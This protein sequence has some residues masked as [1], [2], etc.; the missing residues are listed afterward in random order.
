VIQIYLRNISLVYKDEIKISK[1]EYFYF[2]EINGSI[3]HRPCNWDEYLHEID[4]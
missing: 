4:Y 3:L 1:E 2:D